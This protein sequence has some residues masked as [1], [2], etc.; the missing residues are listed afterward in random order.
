[1]TTTHRPW[2]RIAFLDAK[3]E[4]GRGNAGPYQVGR[5]TQ[6]DLKCRALA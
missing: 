4:A 5:V 1:M 2:T 3:I 6:P